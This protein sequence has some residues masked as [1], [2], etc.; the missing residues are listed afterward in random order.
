MLAL[1]VV[2]LK[3]YHCLASC[4]GPHRGGRDTM[5]NAMGK[6]PSGQESEAVSNGKFE[7]Y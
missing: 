6:D 7:C 2:G 4:E 5:G 3:T 1:I